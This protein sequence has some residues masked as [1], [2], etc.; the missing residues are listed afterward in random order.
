MSAAQ[1]YALTIGLNTVGRAY[2]GYPRAHYARKKCQRYRGDW[3]IQGIRD[4]DD[5]GEPRD[6]QGSSG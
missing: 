1:G 5:P 3:A 4:Q 6:P 2:S